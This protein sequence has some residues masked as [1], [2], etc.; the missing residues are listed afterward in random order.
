MLVTDADTLNAEK[1]KTV[2]VE[3]RYHY[4][5]FCIELWY[6]LHWNSYNNKII[7]NRLNVLCI[8]S[9]WFNYIILLLVSLELKLTKYVTHFVGLQVMV[10]IL[11]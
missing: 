11:E 10:K 7:L 2:H 4:D 9:L 8:Q 6:I 3:Q 5:T 1:R